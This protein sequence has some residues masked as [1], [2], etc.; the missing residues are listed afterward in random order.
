MEKLAIYTSKNFGL[1]FQDEGQTPMQSMMSCQACR[2]SSKNVPSPRFNRMMERSH[3]NSIYYRKDP[4]K[5]DYDQNRLNKAFGLTNKR[6]D[7][8]VNWDKQK[9]RDMS[10]YRQTEALKNIENE[11]ERFKML[12]QILSDL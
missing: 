11:N 12:Q 5:D 7:V 9:N 10:M 8:H 2:N 6:S 3:V 1:N 4:I